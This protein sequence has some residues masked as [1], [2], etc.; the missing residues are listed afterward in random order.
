MDCAVGGGVDCTV[1]C[2]IERGQSRDRPFQN[3]FFQ[4]CALCLG[5]VG[6]I[7]LLAEKENMKIRG[8]NADSMRK[9]TPKSAAKK[10]IWFTEGA[11]SRL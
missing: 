7:R 3:V 9:V 4:K 6:Q 2:Q 5:Q 8:K 11:K 1:R 10:V